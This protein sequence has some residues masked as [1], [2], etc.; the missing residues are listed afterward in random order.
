[1]SNWLRESDVDAAWLSLDEGDNDPIRF[2]QYL[3]AA[4]QTIVPAPQIAPPTMQEMQQL[5]PGIMIN[6]V[7]NDVAGYATPF[8]LILGDFHSIHTPAIFV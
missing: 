4:L 1:V 8:I 7:I 3:G 5:R 6:T 2:L